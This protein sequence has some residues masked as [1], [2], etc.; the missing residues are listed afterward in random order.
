[1]GLEPLSGANGQARWKTD[2]YIGMRIRHLLAWTMIVMAGVTTAC[3]DSPSELATFEAHWQCDV[4]RQSWGDLTEMQAALDQRL[5]VEGLTQDGY[6]EFKLLLASD[7]GER[8]AVLSAFET[9]CAS[10]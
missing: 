7:A 3:S 8:A 10:P 1:M 4:Q 2:R 6:A 5:D 9:Y